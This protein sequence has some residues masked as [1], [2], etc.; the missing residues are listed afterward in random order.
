[1]PY[2]W[3]DRSDFKTVLEKI[4]QCFPS[5][6]TQFL[7]QHTSKYQKRSKHFVCTRLPGSSMFCIGWQPDYVRWVVLISATCSHIK[8]F[9]FI[10][11]T[12]RPFWK[13]HCCYLISYIL[14]VS[15]HYMTI[16]IAATLGWGLTDCLTGYS[17][18]VRKNHRNVLLLSL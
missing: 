12:S 3:A 5:G 1:M 18:F 14:I 9:A 11:V 16:W 15:S 13:E 6:I 8:R 17:M 7:N 2:V 4:A 10:Y